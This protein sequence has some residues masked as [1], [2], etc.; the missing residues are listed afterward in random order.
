MDF[1]RGDIEGVFIVKLIKFVD[2]RGFLI[3]TFRQDL[4]PEKLIPLMIL[5]MLNEKPLPVY[6]DGKN[7][8]DWLFVEDRDYYKS[9]IYKGVT[10]KLKANLHNVT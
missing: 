6:G 4:F 2:E 10:A 7:I 3:E 1:I 5:N 8:R 9:L